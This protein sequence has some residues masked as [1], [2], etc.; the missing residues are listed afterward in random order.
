MAAPSSTLRARD[1][2]SSFASGM[3]I[4][5]LIALAKLLIHI[6]FNNRYGYF[7]DE[8]NYMSCGDHLQWGY[9]DQPSL[10]PFLIH[11][12]RAVLGD[13]L[14]AIRF[15]P[16]LA[17]SLLVVQTAVIARE[18]GGRRYALI[19]S[20]ICAV[21]SGQYLSNGS[22][23]GTNCLEPN[24]WLG[25]A[26]FATLAI[27]RSDPRYWL[28]FGV[29]AGLG[30]EEK[31]S[32]ALF[33]FGIVVGLLLTEQ[34]RIFVNKWIWLGGLAAFLIFLPNL[35]WNMHYDWPFVQLM[36]NIKAEHRDVVLGP[37][38]FFL[39]QLL[40]DNPLTAPIWLTGLFAL[41][42]SARFK[43]YRLLGW[44]Y[45]VCYA[46]FY[47]LHGK[48]Y[49]LAPVYPMLMAAGAVMIETALDGTA[50]VGH[51]EVAPAEVG[52]AEEHSWE[53]PEQKVP[54]GR[55]S[56]AQDVSPGSRPETGTSPGRTARGLKRALKPAIVIVLVLGGAYIAPIVIPVFT[57]DHFLAYAKT[58]P[59]KLPVMEHSHARA[60]L[61]QWYADQF[62]WQEI[63]DETA[64]AWNRLTPDE[65][66]SDP[67]K[68]CG[69][70]AQ[71]YGQAGAIDFL[72]RRYGLPRSLSG[73]QT[74]FLWGPGPYSGNCMIVLDDRKEVLEKLWQQVDYVGTSAPNPYAL[75]QQ[76]DVFIC[77]GKKFDSWP[78]LWPKIKRWR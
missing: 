65:R 3:T 38:D 22:L 9:V 28:W 17:S 31:Y 14:R 44:C 26:Y 66:G 39:Q 59:F 2:Q 62:G 27:K 57:P 8:F 47:I 69:I 61:P 11:I 29:I 15:I 32:I 41:L 16:A 4:I 77:R 46:V 10:I 74:W 60:A 49:Y 12:S 73:H 51:P 20:A 68:A 19:L 75:E 50:G 53:H 58:L 25:C 78:A 71:D 42:F 35:L 54:Q 67:A 43:P 6:Y 48:M 63:V 24:L 52:P 70:F 72:G 33:G 23:L 55:H 64:A 5:W 56:L 1:R 18:L 40:L 45:L 13:S 34:R 30:M 76:I 37:V 7:R 36:H 21:I